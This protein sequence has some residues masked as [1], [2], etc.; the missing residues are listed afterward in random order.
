LILSVI[1][2]VIEDIFSTSFSDCSIEL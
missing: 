2:E 1:N